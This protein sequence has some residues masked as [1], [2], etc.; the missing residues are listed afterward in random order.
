MKWLR[1]LFNPATKSIQVDLHHIGDNEYAIYVANNRSEDI[2]VGIRYSPVHAL[3][4]TA[5]LEVR[6]HGVNEMSV[7]SRGLPKVYRYPTIPFVKSVRL[8]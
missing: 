2:L 7:K 6:P 5:F 3:E 4:M 1:E 8:R